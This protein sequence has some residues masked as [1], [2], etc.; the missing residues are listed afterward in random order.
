MSV[1]G[2]VGGPFDGT[3]EE[4]FEEVALEAGERLLSESG[5]AYVVTRTEDGRAVAEYVGQLPREA[6]PAFMEPIT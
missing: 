2:F 3:E 6:F 1:L 4:L 5:Y